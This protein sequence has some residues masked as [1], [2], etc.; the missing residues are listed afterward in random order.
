MNRMNQ[1][2]SDKKS[3]ALI[4]N[5]EIKNNRLSQRRDGRKT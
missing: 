3:R 5:K 2:A 4:K 1:V